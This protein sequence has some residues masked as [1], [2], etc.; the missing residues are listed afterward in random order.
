MVAGHSGQLIRVHTVTSKG[1]RVS[2][3]LGEQDVQYYILKA[4]LRY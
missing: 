2:Q 3:V 1:L 4:L